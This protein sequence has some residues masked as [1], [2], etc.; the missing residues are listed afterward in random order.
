MIIS[1]III[2]PIMSEK[3]VKSSDS[4]NKYVFEVNKNT[5]KLEIKRAIE[6]RFNVK[7]KKVS[8][9]NQLGKIKNT[10]MRS[11]GKVIRTSGRRS[12]Y[13]KAIVTLIDGNKIDLVGGEL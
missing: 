11:G 13:K 9:I 4:L 12:S 10:S 7:V 6:M 3:S 5:N 8:T 2:R 1:D